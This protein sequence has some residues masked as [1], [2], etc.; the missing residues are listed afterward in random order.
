MSAQVELEF[1]NFPFTERTVPADG[2]QC[3]KLLRHLQSIGPIT[4]MEAFDLYAI[5]T[6][7]Q[8]MTEIGRNWPIKKEWYKTPGGA[9]VK[10]YSLERG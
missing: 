6:C 8:R 5:T 1:N 2:T 3:G 7:G 4:T 10:R 9:N